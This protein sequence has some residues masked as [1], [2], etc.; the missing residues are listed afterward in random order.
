MASTTRIWQINDVLVIESSKLILA[1]PSRTRI[2]PL[3]SIFF[4]GD[5]MLGFFFAC[6]RHA[7]RFMLG[8]SKNR[9]YVP[10]EEFM[11]LNQRTFTFNWSAAI[12]IQSILTKVCVKCA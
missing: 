3:I 4:A 6:S 8:A 2:V 1:R 12:P 7:L 5:D 9:N 10:V 11:V